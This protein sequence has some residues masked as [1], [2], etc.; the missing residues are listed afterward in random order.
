MNE[1]PILFSAPMVR[2]ILNGW[3]TQTRRVVQVGHIP[4]GTRT[5]RWENQTADELMHVAR[6]PYGV[7]GD[8]LWVREAFAVGAFKTI[9]RADW[10]EP[11]PDRPD[12]YPAHPD[13]SWLDE[14]QRHCGADVC[15]HEWKPSIHMPRA[16]SRL[17]L[18]VT[19]VRVERV[20]DISYADVVAEG[21]ATHAAFLH[22]FYGL[23]KRAPKASD[24]WVWVIGFERAE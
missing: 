14:M 1:R 22:T 19:V 15:A 10:G 17:T 7:P 13:A 2:A 24:P 6:C 20:K 4:A 23:N 9:Y 12:K 8:R 11:E 21:F 3:K 16:C 18:E 5:L